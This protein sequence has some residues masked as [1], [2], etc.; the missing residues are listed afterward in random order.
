MRLPTLSWVFS[1]ESGLMDL[2]QEIAVAWAVIV[3]AY[4]AVSYVLG[5]LQ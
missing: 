4:V 2:Q 3:V 5:K 1:G